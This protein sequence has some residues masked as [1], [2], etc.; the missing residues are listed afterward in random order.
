MA[1]SLRRQGRPLAGKSR[2]GLVT[3]KSDLV[4][5]KSDLVTFR[6]DL[7]T[8]KSDLVTF[9]NDLVTFRTGLVVLSCLCMGW[10]QV[11]KGSGR[12]AEIFKIFRNPLA[13]RKML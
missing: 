9:C 12:A 6:N 11:G 8:F 3:F 7:V 10:Q 1:A 13:S 2:N 5:F 4:T